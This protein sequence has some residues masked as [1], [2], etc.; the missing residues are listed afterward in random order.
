[1]ISSMEKKE[2]LQTLPHKRVYATEEPMIRLVGFVGDHGEIRTTMHCFLM[3]G[4]GEMEVTCNFIGQTSTH[5]P[6][7]ATKI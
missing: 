6:Q 2:L 7:A 4:L 5:L 3:K 1:M